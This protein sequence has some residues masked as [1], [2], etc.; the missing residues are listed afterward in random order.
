MFSSGFEVSAKEECRWNAA[1]TTPGLPI[2]SHE[3]D[4]AVS[5]IGWCGFPDVGQGLSGEPATLSQQAC[6][7]DRQPRLRT[8]SAARN[9]YNKNKNE[10]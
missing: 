8:Q 1:S 5:P 3:A 6:L 7:Q 4:P 2:L 9:D 10:Q